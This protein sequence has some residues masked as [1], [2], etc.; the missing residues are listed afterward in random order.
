MKM[1]SCEFKIPDAV[2]QYGTLAL[3]SVSSFYNKAKA[4]GEFNEK[5]EVILRTYLT[6]LSIWAQPEVACVSAAVSIIKPAA[7][8]AIIKQVDDFT[9]KFWHSLSFNQK[10]GIF[11]ISIVFVYINFR[12]TYIPV[13]ILS[14]IPASIFSAKCAVELTL[15]N[16]QKKHNSL[17]KAKES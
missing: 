5:V 3:T 8:S 17:N 11:A 15:D 6:F 10:L 4:E 16:L 14:A 13:S 7:S 9:S 1:S 12:I 2:Q